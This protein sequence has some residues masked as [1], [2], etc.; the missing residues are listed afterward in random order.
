MACKVA[1][2]S[3]LCWGVDEM[4]RVLIIALSTSFHDDG[5]ELYVADTERPI[6]TAN[7]TSTLVF[8]SDAVLVSCDFDT[9]RTRTFF[10]LANF[11]FYFVT[12]ARRL[13]LNFR[14]MEKQITSAIASDEPKTFFSIEKL[15][16]ACIH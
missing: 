15:H 13:S 11:K 3:R 12:L 10:A 16:S 14:Y 1:I 9:D 5:N 8:S 6:D 7:R 2:P 4:F